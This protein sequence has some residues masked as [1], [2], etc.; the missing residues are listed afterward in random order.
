V[1][2]DTDDWRLVAR[3]VEWERKA[4]AVLLKLDAV[5]PANESRPDLAR[6]RV[7]LARQYDQCLQRAI[8]LR[9]RS[10]FDGRK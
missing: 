4:E 2:S 6:L 3:A 8:N 7:K 10:L 1:I 5:G 9:Q